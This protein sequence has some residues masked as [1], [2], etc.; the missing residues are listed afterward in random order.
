MHLTDNI[1]DVRFVLSIDG[2]GFR[3]LAGLLILKDLMQDLVVDT[4]DEEHPPKPC[5]IFDLICGTS[6]GGLIAIL[7]GRLGLSCETA[8]KVYGELGRV[9]HGE[10]S[11]A[12]NTWRAILSG[13]RF[14]SAAFEET[15]KQIVKHFTGAEEALMRDDDQSIPAKR[16]SVSIFAV[17]F[18]S[19]AS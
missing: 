2:G 16:A 10:A 9:I 18:P 11:S 6:N 19:A 13:V 7:L 12:E 5:Q 14:P 4:A 17:E 1:I 8:I 15:L 3:G